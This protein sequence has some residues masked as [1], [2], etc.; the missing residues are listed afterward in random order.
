VRAARAEG[1]ALHEVLKVEGVS[2][3][4]WSRAD[5]LWKL[6]LVDDRQAFTLYEA[7]L[8]Q[9]EDWLDRDISPLHGDLAAWL[10]FLDAYSAHPRPAELLTASKLGVND[11]SRL[12]RSWE[13]RAAEDASIPAQIAR[14][15][16]GT[17]AP[18][19]PIVVQPA[20][21]RRSRGSAPVAPIHAD[22]PAAAGLAAVADTNLAPGKMRFYRYVAIKASLAN[23][24]GDEAQVLERF[25]VVDF[26]T[27]DAG[28]QAL[29]RDDP[30]LAREYRALLDAQR[31][32]TRRAPTETSAS[33]AGGSGAV[34]SAATAAPSCPAPPTAPPARA[35]LAVAAPAV[36]V[37]SKVPIAFD[38]PLGPDA[39]P[40]PAFPFAGA[41]S[42]GLRPPRPAPPITPAPGLA[43]RLPLE[44]STADL[45]RGRAL[46]LVDAARLP[47]A[48]AV[49]SVTPKGTATPSDVAPFNAAPPLELEDYARFR[50]RL[51]VRGEDDVE[52]LRDY[53]V[54][55]PSIKEVLREKFAAR[56]RQDPEA[57]QQFVELVQTFVAELREHAT[58]R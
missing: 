14:L 28:W 43:G 20:V 25:G 38:T 23:S 32:S 1:F 50:A 35:S 2:A 15:R 27:I 30:E 3:A 6:R 29:L 48:V 42:Q 53:G 45:P 9:A 13:H 31:A 8:A 58:K 54:H 34:R 49:L 41:A 12:T 11:L 19:P 52:T 37:P 24:P 51:A 21:L 4:A 39:P 56:F 46:P 26:A 18:L 44:A 7:E 57:Q 10:A 36:A 5:P 55:S 40:G 16:E 22:T 47:Q 33:S 17:P